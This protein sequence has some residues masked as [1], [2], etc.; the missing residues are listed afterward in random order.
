MYNSADSI[1]LGKFSGNPNDLGAVG[2]TSTATGLLINFLMGF[3][4]GTSVLVSQFYG[5]ENKEKIS[6]TVHTSMVLSLIGGIIILAAGELLSSPLLTLLGTKEELFPAALLYMRIIFLGVPALSVFNFGASIVRSVGDSK[7]PLV[8]LTVTGL[9]NVVLNLVF[10]IAFDMG[11]AGVA[12]ATV[13]S[14]YISAVAICAVLMRTDSEIKFSLKNICIDFKILLA[15]LKISIPSAIQ[16]SFF[17][18][19]NMIMQSAVNTFTAEQV[20]GNS[21]ASTIE[22]FVQ[23][24]L[25]S[26]YTVTLTFVGQSYGA[27]EYKRTRRILLYSIIQVTAIGLVAGSLMTVFA[28]PLASI[29]VDKSA[30]NAGAII[31]AATEKLTLMLIP[32]VMCGYM[33][34][35]TGFLRGWGYSLLPMLSTTFFICV[36]RVIW[37]HIFFPLEVFHSFRML[38]IIYPVTWAATTLFMCCM[39]L[40]ISSKKRLRRLSQAEQAVR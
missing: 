35:F 29:F 13:I 26:Y 17:S 21:V 31:A 7:T 36:L 19:S 11:V 6:K 38:F 1:V 10:V 16:Q 3:C 8:I 24:T 37:V 5:A 15:M 4:A 22:G 39:S 32:Y 20:S 27:K 30:A 12:L 33:D 25:S 14:Q 18:V 2:S 34:T 23:T 9:I 28:S 40:I